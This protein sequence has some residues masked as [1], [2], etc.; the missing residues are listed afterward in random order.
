MT[1]ARLAVLLTALG[2]CG[3]EPDLSRFPACGPDGTCA[4]GSSCLAEVA[5]CVPDCGEQCPELPADGGPDAGDDAG[6]DAGAGAD[7]GV[8]A[9]SDAGLDAGSDAGLDAGL[10]AGSDAGLDAGSD[11]GADAGDDAGPP[12][13][14]AALVLPPAIETK[15]WSTTFVPS[16]GV[17]PYAFSL[18]GGLPGFTLDVGGTLAT[19]AAPTPGVFPF[20]VTVRDDAVP[21]ASVT[22][23]GVLEV[24]PLLRVASRGPLI[25]ARQGQAYSLGLVATGGQAPYTW[26]L[27]GGALP[28]GVELAGDGTLSGT[29]S[30]T[31]TFTFT[32]RTT[33]AATPPQVA[34]RSLSL[35][36]KVLD[37]LLSIGTEAAADGR[38]GTTYSQSLKAYGGTPPYAWTLVSGQYPPGITLVDSGTLGQLG[39]APTQTGTW[40]FTVRCSDGLSSPT[41]ALSIVVY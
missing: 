37:T 11:A 5:R 23:D 38:V 22:R 20:S 21:R 15:P 16:G 29:P 34:V 7:A 27:D 1:R 10:D 25:Q 17:P 36:V 31:G 13:A 12:L 32:A 8:D 18:D 41:Q 9:G 39:G 3:F 30:A 14:L 4:A 40:N 24:R 35:Q 33:D 28:P 2:A 6:L 19:A 26:A